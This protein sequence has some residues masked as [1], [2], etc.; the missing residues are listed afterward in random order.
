MGSEVQGSA[1][2]LA[3]GLKAASQI[4]KETNEHRTLNV[5]L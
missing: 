3:A 5:E 4:Q 2:S 1:F